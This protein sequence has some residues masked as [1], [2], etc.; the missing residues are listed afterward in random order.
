MMACASK[1]DSGSGW[2]GKRRQACLFSS[3]LLLLRCRSIN[4][5][6]M[7]RVFIGLV[8]CCAEQETETLICDLWNYET[9]NNFGKLTSPYHECP[10]MW[11]VCPEEYCDICYVSLMHLSNKVSVLQMLLHSVCPPL[12]IH[13]FERNILSLQRRYLEFLLCEPIKLSYYSIGS[14]TF[15]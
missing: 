13:C 2:I 5:I 8:L 12:H 11:R 9:H 7:H 3:S 6:G 15:T 4:V 14:A 1:I 10:K